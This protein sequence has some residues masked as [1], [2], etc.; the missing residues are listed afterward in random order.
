MKILVVVDSI[1]IED[2]SG[3]KANVALIYN[4]VE[5]G[6]EVLVYH[7]TL[8]NIPLEGVNCF[9]IPEIKYSPLYFLSRLQRVLGRTFNLDVAPFLEKL[10]GFSFTFFN[11]AKSIERALKKSKFQPDLVL[12]LS[13][14]ASFRPHYAVLQLPELHNKWMAYVHDPYPFHYYPRPYTWVESSYKQKETF[15]RQV[16]EK[17][18]HSAFPS[19][20]L[21]EW[22]GSYFPDFLKTGVVIPHQIAKYKFQAS[23]QGNHFPDYFD[24]AKFNLLHAGNLM[25]QRCP[26]GLIEGFQLF[27]NKN[28]DAAK[29][30]KLILLGNASY[31]SKMLEEYQAD[32]PEIYIYN[33][34]LSF[35]AVYQLQKN[36]SV[37][38]IL[39]S[40][41]EI[42]P[43]LPAKFPHCVEANKT[44]LSLT[45]Y[46][47]ETRRLLGYDYPYWAEVDDVE[48]I[49]GLIEKLYQLWKQDP[50]NLL[51]ERSDL[52]EYLSASYLKKV[53]NALKIN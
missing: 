21:L 40:K 15:F 24:A 42:S 30:S 8:K 47:S 28:P 46:Y 49:A 35:D 10:F 31:H 12:S 20:L 25:K 51:L 52:K 41:S 11:D 16:S 18:K 48:K 50:D 45:P 53:V 5:A 43:F 23:G 22:I 19:Q 34:N 39:E 26:Q 7:Y 37:N 29:E 27:L 32:N 3:S 14:G 6:F 44:I 9:A 13:K 2:S 38:I 33:G 36:V 4:L 1:N 17:A